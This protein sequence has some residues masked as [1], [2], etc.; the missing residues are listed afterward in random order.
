LNDNI[1]IRDN[2]YRII[3]QS[4]NKLIIIEE[5]VY[6]IINNLPKYIEINDRNNNNTPIIFIKEYYCYNNDNIYIKKPVENTIDNILENNDYIEEINTINNQL[7]PIEQTTILNNTEIII[8]SICN[9]AFKK[10]GL[11]KWLQRGNINCPICRNN[12]L[13]SRTYLFINN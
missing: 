2:N 8:C 9:S 10:D 4:Y 12:I 6:K 5:D 7:C 3:T 1:I 11:K 13:N